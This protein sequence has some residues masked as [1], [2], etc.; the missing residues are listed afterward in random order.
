MSY[1]PPDT[2]PNQYIPDPNLVLKYLAYD[3]T[4]VTNAMNSGNLTNPYPN[5]AAALAA[6]QALETAIQTLQSDA[7]AAGVSSDIQTDITNFVNTLQAQFF[8]A[9]V[10][11]NNPGPLYNSDSDAA[12]GFT[13][14]F[15]QATDGDGT[16]YSFYDQ[17]RDDYV[18]GSASAFMKR[19]TGAAYTD[20][21]A[22]EGR[23]MLALLR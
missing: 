20:G 7:T 19:Y 11:P 17:A 15:K 2:I 1:I 12:L 6:A 4:K 23:L 14:F 8:D 9:E 5:A 10:D 3:V 18:H 21:G 16:D 13:D 22:A